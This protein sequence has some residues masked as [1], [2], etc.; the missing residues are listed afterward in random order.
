MLSYQHIYHAGCLADIHKHASLC[1]LLSHMVKKDKPLSYIETHAG[2][3]FYDMTSAEAQKTGEAKD[4]IARLDSAKWFSADHPF[5]KVIAHYRQEKGH[6][7]YPG[8]AAMASHLLRTTDKIHLH[9][10]HP[11]EV[12]FLQASMPLGTK[13]YHKDGYEGLLALSPP[14]PRRGFVFIDP[15]FEI[16]SEYELIPDIIAKL[17]KKWSVAVVCIWYPILPAGL[18]KNMIA[19]LNSLNLPQSGVFETEFYTPTEEK[20]GMYGS[21]LFLAN[22]PYNVTPDLNAITSALSGAGQ[23]HSA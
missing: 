19:A 10:L 16:K 18:H 20:R 9:E 4:G 8:S 5:S 11:Q 14:T 3:G 7:I 23:N 2:R 13:I 15:S 17:M 1:V 22:I 12:K 21:G 6:A